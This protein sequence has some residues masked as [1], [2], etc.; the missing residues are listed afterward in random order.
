MNT[1]FA[2]Y[3]YETRCVEADETE[4]LDNEEDKSD[5]PGIILVSHSAAPGSY[6]KLDDE[7]YPSDTLNAS[8]LTDN[9][10]PTIHFRAPQQRGFVRL[11]S[12]LIPAASLTTI[13][14]ESSLGGI[15]T[16]CQEDY[17]FEDHTE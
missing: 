13:P 11:E 5:V 15:S 17:I 9:L 6:N 4:R 1:L 16:L 12:E 2:Y 8:V 10:P 3:G 7:Q 14:E